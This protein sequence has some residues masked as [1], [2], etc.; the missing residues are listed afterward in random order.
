MTVYLFNNGSCSVFDIIIIEYLVPELEEN[1]DRQSTVV[2]PEEPVLPPLPHIPEGP[3]SYTNL[4]ASFAD[5]MLLVCSNS[6][7][8]IA[9]EKSTEILEPPLS[10]EQSE[11]VTIAESTSQ[12]KS[13]RGKNKK[14]EEDSKA[15]EESERLLAKE[16]E[17]QRQL[18][19]RLEQIKNLYQEKE[20][21][22]NLYITTPNALHVSFMHHISTQYVDTIVETETSFFVK[23]EG[24]A[25]MSN[26]PDDD[27]VTEVYRCVTEDG[28]VVQVS[29]AL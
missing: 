21:L 9:I 23:L 4:R 22:K 18:L 15:L 28:L 11:H 20:G 8:A 29:C 5:G 13:A 1:N 25:I 6:V 24:F 16:L 26:S 14:K 12:A 7:D 3:C 27:I 2:S 19:H 10:V 17:N